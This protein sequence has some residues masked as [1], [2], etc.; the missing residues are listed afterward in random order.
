LGDANL[1][2]TELEKYQQVSAEDIQRMCQEI[3]DHTNSNTLY[4]LSQS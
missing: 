3:F 1:M 4:Y 2:N